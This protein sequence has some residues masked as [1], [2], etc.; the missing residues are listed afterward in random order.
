MCRATLANELHTDFRFPVTL[1]AKRRLKTPLQPQSK[2]NLPEKACSCSALVILV[3]LCARTKAKED[4]R[5]TSTLSIACSTCC[6]GPKG[7]GNHC[8]TAIAGNSTLS[9]GILS[10]SS[11]F[12]FHCSC[13]THKNV[14][15]QKKL[16]CLMILHRWK[17]KY[18][19]FNVLFHCCPNI[20][21][22]VMLSLKRETTSI[23]SYAQGHTLP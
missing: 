18:T 23:A 20:S 2:V 13:K 14:K 21:L 8:L 1:S 4:W 6:C 12:S 7:T 5:T 15:Q 22:S 9:S 3:R 16:F 11:P 19:M 10:H 17:H